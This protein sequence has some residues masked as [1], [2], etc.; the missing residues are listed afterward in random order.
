MT[1]KIWQEFDSWYQHEFNNW[2]MY[3]KRTL[4]I[5]FIIWEY[6]EHH[7]CLYA[8]EI[9]INGIIQKKIV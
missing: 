5:G 7:N 3:N 1:C 2:S 9:N 4:F 6:N 8:D